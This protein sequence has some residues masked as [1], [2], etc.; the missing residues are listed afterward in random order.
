MKT[1]SVKSA[2]GASEGHEYLVFF[3]GVQYTT[4]AFTPLGAAEIVTRG[5]CDLVASREGDFYHYLTP[6]KTLVTVRP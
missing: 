5:E 6:N 1:T 3:K 2:L 4:R